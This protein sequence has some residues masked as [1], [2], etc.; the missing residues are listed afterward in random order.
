MNEFTFTVGGLVCRV[1]CDEDAPPVVDSFV[2]GLGSKFL[3]DTV[4]TPH[5]LNGREVLMRDHI[6]LVMTLEHPGRRLISFIFAELEDQN[7]LARLHIIYTL[8][9]FRNQGHA[10]TLLSCFDQVLAKG[11]YTSVILAPAS[12]L[13]LSLFQKYQLITT[14]SYKLYPPGPEVLAMGDVECD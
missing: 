13:S 4:I 3:R 2:N 8:R 7:H 5:H 11:E 10:K 14:L 12:N 9:S 1:I 6:N